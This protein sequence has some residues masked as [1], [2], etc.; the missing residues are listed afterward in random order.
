MAE[1]SKKTDKKK[2]TEEITFY[3][4]E[5]FEV[6][7]DGTAPFLKGY[8]CK[9]C[10]KLWFPRVKYCMDPD[11]WSEDMEVV[12]LSR[13][14][15]IY[16]CV[17]I[18]IG[19]PGIPTPYVWG[20]VDLPDGIRIPTIFDGDVKTFNIGDEVEVIAKPLRKN[21]AGEDIISWSFRKV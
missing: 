4:E 8:R 2:T 18:Y 20:Y 16:T 13:K 21:A 10:N 17:D 12:P 11:C 3:H 1:K 6:S 14:G 15:I 7:K 5:I 19:A 9:K